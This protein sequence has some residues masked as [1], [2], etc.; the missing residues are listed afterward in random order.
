MR[1]AS[2][3]PLR[4]ISSSGPDPADRR[5]TLVRAAE[6]PSARVAAVRAAGVEE[7]LAAALGPDA[8]PERLAEVTA[9]PTVLARHLSARD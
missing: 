3:S 4:A 1:S 5:R 9:A 7:A 8:G 6:R 2:P